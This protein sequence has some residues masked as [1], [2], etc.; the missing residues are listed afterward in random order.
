MFQNLLQ[1]SS[2][3]N[4]FYFFSF[5]KGEGEHQ[6][7]GFTEVNRGKNPADFEVPR[8]TCSPSTSP[9]KYGKKNTRYRLNNL[10]FLWKIIPHPCQQPGQ[11]ILRQFGSLLLQLL[12]FLLREDKHS[13]NGPFWFLRTSLLKSTK[14]L[15]VVELW[16]YIFVFL[17]L[18]NMENGKW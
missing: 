5:F 16:V 17:F 18:C 13:R 14:G 15:V 3:K 6:D 11:F 12:A 9:Q 1:V 8:H 10:F 7:P 2:K 4:V